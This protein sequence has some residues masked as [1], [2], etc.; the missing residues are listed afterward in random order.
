[1]LVFLQLASLVALASS[2]ATAAGD[3]PNP[4]PFG[5]DKRSPA[6]VPAPA[7]VNLGWHALEERQTGTQPFVAAR[8]LSLVGNDNRKR[9]TGT[10][11]VE[12]IG[13]S[14]PAPAADELNNLGD[15][16]ALVADANGEMTNFARS[17]SSPSSPL[18]LRRSP[19][20]IPEPHQLN[21][22]S[23]LFATRGRADGT[24]EL[25]KV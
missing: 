15:T 1:M 2:F 3:R 8:D 23:H 21:R 20:P 25:I 6:P 4:R 7:V 18:K 22:I 19:H 14:N 9:Q 24:I 13:T 16:T 10:Q 12:V 11:P 5:L 17:L